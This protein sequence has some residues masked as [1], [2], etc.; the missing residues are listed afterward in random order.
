VTEPERLL[1]LDEAAARLGLAPPTVADKLRAGELPGFKYGRLWRVR[2]KDLDA[3][4]RD[5]AAGKPA[6]TPTR[7]RKP[8]PPRPGAAT[9]RRR[10]QPA[11]APA[12]SA[13]SD[14][15]DDAQDREPTEA[16]RVAWA[17]AGAPEA[18][19]VWTPEYLA[20]LAEQEAA[21]AAGEAP[22]PPAA[23]RKRTP[24]TGGTP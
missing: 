3:L 9:P 15:D 23:P 10:A 8:R 13:A 2:E 7:P 4:I 1:S 18:E 12:P 24:K 16:E 19:S 20:W 21:A 14:A 11:A 6:P 17:R 5:L 22:Q